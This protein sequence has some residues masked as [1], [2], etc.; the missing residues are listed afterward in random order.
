MAYW[1]EG[2]N[3]FNCDCRALIIAGQDQFSVGYWTFW[4]F[5][6]MLLRHWYHS[7]CLNWDSLS[8]NW[9]QM[10][11]WCQILNGCLFDKWLFARVTLIYPIKDSLWY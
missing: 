6:R 5:I 7:N 11:N 1:I 10:R 2:V 8:L 9:D 3:D 4:S